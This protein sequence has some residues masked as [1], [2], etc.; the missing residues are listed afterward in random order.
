MRQ[1]RA[2]T[3]IIPCITQVPNKK[4]II[5]H[6]PVPILPATKEAKQMTFIGPRNPYLV[7]S[8][9]DLSQRLTDGVLRDLGFQA[10]Y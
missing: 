3:G 6:A 7:P 1:K 8:C 10:S 2:L 5:A 4:W 9:S